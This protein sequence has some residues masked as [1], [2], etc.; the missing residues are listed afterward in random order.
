[1]Y[2]EFLQDRVQIRKQTLNHEIVQK[3]LITCKNSKKS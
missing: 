3:L 1:M 2:F